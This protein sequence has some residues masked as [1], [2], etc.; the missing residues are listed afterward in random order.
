MRLWSSALVVP[1]TQP[2]IGCGCGDASSC[3]A[4]EQGIG[5]DEVNAEGHGPSPLNSVFG[6]LRCSSMTSFRSALRAAIAVVAVC[7][8]APSEAMACACVASAESGEPAWPTL[9][10][11]VPRTEVAFIG[12]VVSQSAIPSPDEPNVAFLDVR[13]TRSIK[14]PRAGTI[15]RVW[16]SA[17]GSSC[18][19][20]LRPLKNGTIA[21]FA[22]G[23]NKPEYR[24]FQ[25]LLHISVEADAYLIGSCGEYYRPLASEDE[26]RKLA[27]LLKAQRH[28]K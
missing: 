6:G 22:L 13:V 10:Q 1:Y 18:A 23:R 15:V 19:G 14:G 9:E 26:A 20:D 2:Q 21:A 12:R 3:S 8:V 25:E 27:K 17:F 5:A 16:D 11:A 4:V 28:G 7:L 24:E